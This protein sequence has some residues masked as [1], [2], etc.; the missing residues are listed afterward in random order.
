[1]RFAYKASTKE[2]KIRSGTIES[3]SRTDAEQILHQEDLS[4]L[5]LAEKHSG[6]RWGELE[7]RI[8]RVSGVDRMLFVKHLAI[9]LK[10]GIALSEALDIVMN[11]TSSRRMQSVIGSVLGNVMNG[12][13]LASS[14]SQHPRVFSEL[15]VSMVKVGE[16]S[17]T[18]D[19]TLEYLATELE[20]EYELKKRVRGAMIYPAIILIAT[21]LLGAFLS[22]F[23][24]PKLVTLFTNLRIE[25]PPLT[26]A[27]VSVAKFMARWGIVVFLGLIAGMGALRFLA[28]W[29]PTQPMFHRV[30]L[31]TPFVK[32]LA[33][34]INLARC[35]HVLGTLLK[36]GI[37]ILEALRIT[38]QTVGNAVY[39]D[40]FRS[41]WEQVQRGR[42][43]GDVFDEHEQLFPRMVSRMTAVGEKTGQLDESLLYLARF[44]EDEVDHATKN[45]A[46]IIEPALLI[47]IGVVL[48]GLAIAIITPIYQISGS[49]RR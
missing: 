10:S 30:Y 9:M 39:K 45:L 7:L 34:N 48:G 36:S 29:K 3:P 1:M 12:S 8:G 22:V 24:L 32:R 18:L 20:K 49:L 35:T 17:G 42:S 16:E 23:I 5:T 19:R 15:I 11:E 13:T 28:R 25:L 4:V 43:L 6:V 47:V 37:P 33:T 31:K 2:G 14:L 26:R 21:F 41:A 46:V 38:E 27:L 44:Y 40:V